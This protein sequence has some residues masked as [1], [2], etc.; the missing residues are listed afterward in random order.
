MTG[1]LS[2]TE[3]M[4]AVEDIAKGKEFIPAELRRKLDE[5]TIYEE[6]T[7]AE[8]G[9]LRMMVGGLSNR[10]IA[11]ALDVS[12]NNVKTQVKHIFEKM[13]VADRTSATVAAIRRGHVRLD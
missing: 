5:N 8:K 11:F 2:E 13:Q 7:S 1:G 4:H 10:E 12:E 3:I 6:L 9:V